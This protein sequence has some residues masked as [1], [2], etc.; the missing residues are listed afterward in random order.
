MCG[1]NEK[2]EG[3]FRFAELQLLDLPDLYAGKKYYGYIVCPSVEEV[4]KRLN[5]SA[6][7]LNLVNEFDA[8]FKQMVGGF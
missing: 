5:T 3:K 1:V 2:V 7:L 4:E 8:W 6:D